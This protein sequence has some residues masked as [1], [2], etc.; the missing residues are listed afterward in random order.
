MTKK[1]AKAQ[2]VK[3]TKTVGDRVNAG[4]AK[5]KDFGKNMGT[6]AKDFGNKAK[7]H[8]ARNR[9][10]YIAGG[11]GLAAGAVGGAALARRKKAQNKD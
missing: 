3:A 8:V 4:V 6:K 9:A 2:P 11:A 7:A 5:V 1:A 10:A